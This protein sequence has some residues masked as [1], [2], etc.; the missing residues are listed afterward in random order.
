MADISFTSFN[1]R[2]F[3]QFAQTLAAKI[4]GSGILIFGDGADGGR[5]AAYTGRVPY[6]T[7][8]DNWDGY[9]VMQA[10]FR[11]PIDA[12]SNDADWLVGQFRSEM[13]TLARD[14]NRKRPDYYILVTNIRL[15]GIEGTERKGGQQKMREAFKKYGE[16]L[17]IRKLDIWH[18]ERIAV[19]LDTVPDVLTSYD[20]WLTPRELLSAAFRYF[21]A[22]RPDF[23]QV[24]ARYLQREFRSLRETRLQQAGHGG[25]GIALEQLFI[26]LPCENQIYQ[27][28]A[29]ELGLGHP[30]PE[31]A[32]P[33][34]LQTLLGRIALKLDADT[35]AATWQSAL[36]GPAP[37]RQL[38]LGGPGQGK[39]T[40]SQF[41]GQVARWR[42]LDAEPPTGL[43]PEAQR[44][45]AEFGERAAVLGIAADGVRRYPVRVDLPSF[46]DALDRVAREHGRL[47]LLE[48]ITWHIGQIATAD[49]EVQDVRGW[50]GAYPWLLLLDGLDEVPPSGNRV[51]VIGAIAEF[52]DEAAQL[53]ADVAMIVT[54]RPQGYNDDLDPEYY[55][56]LELTPLGKDRALLYADRLALLRLQDDERRERVLKRLHAAADNPATE[57]LMVSPLQVAILFQLVDQRGPAPTD[58]WSLFDDYLEIFIKREQEKPGPAGDTMRKHVRHITNLV[59]RAGLLLHT[60]AEGDGAAAAYLSAQQ[61]EMLA[62][63]LLLEEG[64]DAEAAREIAAEIV[65]A[66][67]D[68]LAFLEQREEGR[69]SFEVRSLQEYAAAAAIMAGEQTAVRARLRHI[70]G[71]AHWQHVYRIAASKAFAHPDAEVFRDAILVIN[72][73]LDTQD[74]ASRAVALGAATSLDLVDDGLAADHPGYRRQLV[75]HALGIVRLGPQTA[76]QRLVRPL[77]ELGESFVEAQLV[78]RLSAARRAEREAAWQLLLW[79]SDEV[80]WAARMA[81]R[82]WPDDPKRSAEVALLAMPNPPGAVIDRFEHAISEAHLPSLYA[83]IWQHNMTSR[84]DTR[85]MIDDSFPSLMVIA[86]SSLPQ[87]NEVPVLIPE[88]QHMRL[89][90]NT[91]DSAKHITWWNDAMTAD[92]PGARLVGAFVDDPCPETLAAFTRA[93]AD[94]ELVE[95]MDKLAL[96]WPLDTMVELVKRGGDADALSGRA[97]RGGFAARE[98]WLAAEDRLTDYGLTKADLALWSQGIFFDERVAEVGAPYFSSM[99]R[100]SSERTPKDW[101]RPLIEAAKVSVDGGPLSYLYFMLGGAL[102]N[103][104]ADIR[105]AEDFDAVFGTGLQ[106]QR[107]SAIRQIPPGALVDA[108][109]VDRLAAAGAAGKILIGSKGDERIDDAVVALAATSGD[110]RLLAVVVAV[111]AEQPLKLSRAAGILNSLAAEGMTSDIPDVRRAAAVLRFIGFELPVETVLTMVIDEEADNVAQHAL[112]NYATS[113]L[114]DAERAGAILATLVE[115]VELPAPALRVEARRELQR[116]LAAGSTSLGDRDMWDGFALPPSLN[117]RLR[118]FFERPPTDAALATGESISLDR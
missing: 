34:V 104:G 116:L 47:S 55:L 99:S 53:G 66:A 28:E 101:A 89:D 56:K 79:M 112:G 10:K 19:L 33:L 73:E 97:E 50:L 81:V 113:A 88:S 102:E 37:T 25:E 64:Y 94:P 49:V 4:L 12:R 109:L 72:R 46:A 20:A 11:H 44:A 16:P 107:A 105:S 85:R 30:M 90:L 115:R 100:S 92:W 18:A 54:T 63:D 61:L 93:L 42:L 96:A 48:Y 29:A 111:L 110:P 65:V 117:A 32:E 71:Y 98:D 9:I 68:R 78:P 14:K 8:V 84:F 17:G 57:A 108:A 39:S 106:R 23:R 27:D 75:E 87:S 69:Y 15:S 74:D 58:R 77:V 118:E 36:R 1:S 51:A 6:P 35:L 3:E 95:A 24:I 83:T 26:D 60:A 91:L 103:G 80:I 13:Q 41:L 22:K 31:I 76:N 43:A 40:I 62:S 67:T 2:S 82:H 114:A 70:A 86:S 59:R 5:E 45:L 38:L 7:P 52:W 21:T